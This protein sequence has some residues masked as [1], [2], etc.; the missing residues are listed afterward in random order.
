MKG[1]VPIVTHREPELV[2][3]EA[4]RNF[5]GDTEKVA[6][7]G[8]NDINVRGVIVSSRYQKAA[9]L[10]AMIKIVERLRANQ[11]GQV[12]TIWCDSKATCCYSVVLRHKHLPKAL[13]QDIFETLR[14]ACID[15]VGGYNCLTLSEPDDSIFGGDQLFEDSGYW[16]DDVV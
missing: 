15:I 10:E 1:D 16:R 7:A 5:R 8:F 4:D 3:R 9:E 12:A 11:V 14:Q 13:A 2:Q 6:T